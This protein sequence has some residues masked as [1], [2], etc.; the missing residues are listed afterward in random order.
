MSNAKLPDS[1]AVPRTGERLTR[2]AEFARTGKG[3]WSAKRMLGVVLE[4]LRGAELESLSRKH[5]VN[6]A[7]LSQWREAFLAEAGLNDLLPEISTRDNL[8]SSVEKTEGS[9]H[10]EADQVHR[11]TND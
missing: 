9:D 10:D 4:L 7:A 11:R 3:R 1:G 6:V 2:D 5:G 8:E